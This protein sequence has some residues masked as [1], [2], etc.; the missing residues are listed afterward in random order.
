MNQIEVDQEVQ[1][2]DRPGERE[3]ERG[4]GGFRDDEG[5]SAFRILTNSPGVKTPLISVPSPL[6][7]AAEVVRGLPR[8]RCR[9]ARRYA[10]RAA[11]GAGWAILVVVVVVG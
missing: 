11:G 1:R 2:G 9:Y 7:K 6:R 3:G 8:C 4:G 5:R 10:R